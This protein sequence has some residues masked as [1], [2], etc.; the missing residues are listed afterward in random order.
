MCK[1]TCLGFPVY[2]ELMK[3]SAVFKFYR[4][5]LFLKDMFSRLFICFPDYSYVIQII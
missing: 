5:S 1:S 2:K 3:Q 4:F